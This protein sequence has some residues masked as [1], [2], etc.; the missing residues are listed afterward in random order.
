MGWGLSFLYLP[1]FD[2]AMYKCCI[3]LSETHVMYIPS[4]LELS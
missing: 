4:E 1:A 2:E 3:A